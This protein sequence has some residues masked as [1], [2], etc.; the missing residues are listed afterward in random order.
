MHIYFSSLS[1][2]FANVLWYKIEL[3]CTS[4]GMWMINIKQYKATWSYYIV[5]SH[6]PWVRLPFPWKSFSQK[7]KIFPIQSIVIL[8]LKQLLGTK[9][10]VVHFLD[11]AV[12][13]VLIPEHCGFKHAKQIFNFNL[14]SKTG[15]FCCSH[16]TSRSSNNYVIHTCNTWRPLGRGQDAESNWVNPHS[17]RN[18]SAYSWKIPL[19]VFIPSGLIPRTLL[20]SIQ[21]EQWFAHFSA[22]DADRMQKW[23]HLLPQPFLILS[24]L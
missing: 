21:R 23:H 1:L 10:H 13:N 16:F 8:N 11:T 19:T 2:K 12:P 15:N 9:L 20:Q 22:S 18:L 7:S 14:L 17:F 24:A 3:N 5:C 4:I 6:V